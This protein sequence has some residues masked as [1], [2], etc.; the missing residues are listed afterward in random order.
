V[1]GT[2]FT[3][4]RRGDHRIAVSILDL[5][6]SR[7]GSW[8]SGTAP[9]VR[10]EVVVTVVVEHP[11]RWRAEVA[12]LGIDGGRFTSLEIESCVMREGRGL[13]C[14]VPMEEGWSVVR[15]V[16]GRENRGVS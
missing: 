12:V 14:R 13:R 1:G 11:E 6:G 10:D 15:W 9:G 3:R 7:D 4:V 8:S 5:R 16:E 2:L